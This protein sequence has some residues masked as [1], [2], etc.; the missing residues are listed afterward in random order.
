M[1]GA[2]RASTALGCSGFLCV[3]VCVFLTVG[4]ILDSYI[5]FLLNDSARIFGAW[6]TVEGKLARLVESWS[7]RAED[8][9]FTMLYFVL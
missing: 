5:C 6:F 8:L 2:W 4:P 7:S 1:P 3:C 9:T